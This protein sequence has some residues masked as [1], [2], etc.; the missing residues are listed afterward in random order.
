[1]GCI[2]IVLI[3]SIMST[4]TSTSTSTPT[5][6][7]SSSPLKTQRHDGGQQATPKRRRLRRSR[8]RQGEEL[9]RP[10]PRRAAKQ[11]GPMEE[12]VSH[13]DFVKLVWIHKWWPAGTKACTPASAA[14]GRSSWASAATT[15][16][17]LIESAG[18][19]AHTDTLSATW[20]S[21]WASAPRTQTTGPAAH[22]Q[23]L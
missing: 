3:I 16:G 17:G 7:S 22:R 5:S 11:Y 6:P 18:A 4:S 12:S 9:L 2:I 8:K 19:Q 10:R 14:T 21:T 20:V 15:M 1:M 13:T 23:R